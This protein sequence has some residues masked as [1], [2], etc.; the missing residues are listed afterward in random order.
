M[1]KITPIKVEILMGHKVT[2]AELFKQSTLKDGRKAFIAS[3][4]SGSCIVI[5]DGF[6]KVIRAEKFKTYAYSVEDGA[7]R[8][9]GKANPQNALDDV[10][11]TTEKYIKYPTKA[12]KTVEGVKN[13]VS[14]LMP[15]KSSFKVILESTKIPRGKWVIK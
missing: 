2:N 5:G 15:K 1:T 11:F 6:K 7:T 13:F 12:V 3:L 9:I 10:K 4:P 14:K 8:K